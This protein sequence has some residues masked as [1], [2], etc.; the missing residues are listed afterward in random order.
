MDDGLEE[1]HETFTVTLKNPQNAVL[2]QRSS[3]SVEIIDPRGGEICSEA[4]G[5]ILLVLKAVSDLLKV[6][7]RYKHQRHR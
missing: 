2:G 4:H 7:M 5:L 1:T 6:S 3:A